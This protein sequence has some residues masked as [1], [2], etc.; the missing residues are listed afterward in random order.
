MYTQL[1]SVLM[2]K[3]KVILMAIVAIVSGMLA[4]P[5]PTHAQGLITALVCTGTHAATWTPGVTSNPNTIQVGAQ[6]NW[7]CANASGGPVILNAAS[8]SSFNATFSCGSIFAPVTATWTITWTDLDGHP[9]G[10][11]QY[12]FTARVTAVENNLVIA[13]PGS[14]TGGQFA[15]ATVVGSFILENLAATVQNGCNVPG[16]VTN[17]SGASTLTITG[18]NLTL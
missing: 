15:G 8:T 6:S 1:K 13:A 2:A 4:M 5:S 7:T 12:Q 11:S 18:L 9:K 10:Q 16:G 17:G 14:I 3:S